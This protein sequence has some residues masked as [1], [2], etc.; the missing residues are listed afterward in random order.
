[1]YNFYQS[2]LWKHINK[3]VY[4]KPTIDVEIFWHRYQAILWQKNVFG[5]EM[6]W[7]QVLGLSGLTEDEMIKL[8]QELI[9]IQRKYKA[10]CVQIGFNDVLHTAL[11]VDIEK[12]EVV[13]EFQ[14]KKR[15]ITRAMKEIGFYR[16]HKENL[17]PS[18]YFINLKQTLPEI[19]QGMKKKHRNMIN[20]AK[21]HNIICSVAT[22]EQAEEFYSLLVH[23]GHNKGFGVVW[24]KAFTQLITD[25]YT[26]KTGKLYI[27]TLEDKIIW[28]AVYLFDRPRHTAIYLYGATDR[29]VGNIGVGQ[30]MHWYLFEDLQKEEMQTIDMLGGAP[31]WDSKHH[32]ASVGSFKEWFGGEKVEFVWSF[33]IVYNKFVYMLWKIWYMYKHR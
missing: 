6:N 1:M 17:P 4:H 23:T 2:A 8:R 21:R 16:S 13:A 22:V 18:T 24:H 14:Q 27:T 30:Y 26:A 33:D 29:S 10:C 31:T 19:R 32:F 5:M 12:D 15:A 9:P 25:L 28:G 11:S 20:K 7:V 3:E